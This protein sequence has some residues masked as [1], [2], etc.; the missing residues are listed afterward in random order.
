M[1]YLELEEVQWPLD[2]WYNNNSGRKQKQIQTFLE[3][4]LDPTYFLIGE[5]NSRRNS[6]R[7]TFLETTPRTLLE[8]G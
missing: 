4:L 6:L 2:H 1:D 7:N 3:M 8:L 5:F